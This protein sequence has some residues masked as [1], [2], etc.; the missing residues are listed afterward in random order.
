DAVRPIL[1]HGRSCGTLRVSTAPAAIL[2]AIWSG[3]APMLGLTALLVGAICALQYAAIAR[4]LR[5]TKQILAG[6]DRLAHGDLA[7]RLPRFRLA[8]LERISTV[9]NA[10]A[11]SLDRTTRERTALAARLVDGAEQERRR[12]ARELHDD[13]AQ[14]LS[15]IGAL[16]A[17]IRTTAAAQCPALAAEAED[18]AEASRATM[19]SLR[20]TLQTLRPPELDDLGL[21]ASLAALAREHE[22]R[23]GGTLRISLEIAAGLP[24]LPPAAAA[25]VY[26][27]VQEGLTNIARHAHAAHA[28]I[29]LAPRPASSAPPWLAL[30]IEDDGTPA[31]PE[32]AGPER[33]E[34][35][36][37][38]QAIHP[39]LG[40][41]ALGLPAFGLIGMR[42]R[43]L[44]LG[45][46]LEAARLAPRGFRL[47]AA[48]PLVTPPGATPPLAT[49]P[50]AP[51]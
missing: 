17:S 51:P 9:F 49:P 40:L 18:L 2:A 50:G 5:P 25:H 35:R 41:P 16:A 24:E 26:R 32:P 39:A 37:E 43:V 21:A 42:E 28:R 38:S 45:G 23:A 31:P 11:A 3:I 47:H 12:L 30:T 15:A 48:F 4:A 19:R 36:R 14:T 8:E 6:L 13:L 10:L 20:T 22:R 27:I 29:T 1:C 33:D 7:C 34:R 44:A 46:E